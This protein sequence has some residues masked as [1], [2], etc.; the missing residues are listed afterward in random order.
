MAC[1]GGGQQRFR[2]L[3]VNEAHMPRKRLIA[4]PTLSR[5]PSN[6]ITLLQQAV[7]AT[8]DPANDVRYHIAFRCKCSISV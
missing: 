4:S 6:E 7:V 3:A 2:F 1:I 5:T 8:L